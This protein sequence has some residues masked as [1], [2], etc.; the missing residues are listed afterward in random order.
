MEK[1]RR[2]AKKL[3]LMGGGQSCIPE[4]IY[5]ALSSPVTSQHHSDFVDI[6]SVI[7]AQL[8]KL[9]KT[10]NDVTLALPGTGSAGME[11][12]F[13]N[14]VEPGD[15]VLILIN[16]YFGQRMSDVASRLGAQVDTFAVPWGRPVL[17]ED[18]KAVLARRPYALVAMVHAETSTGATSPMEALGHLVRRSSE[19]LF[20][21]DCVSSLGGMAVDVDR[22]QADAA[23]SATQKCLSCPTGLAPLTISARAL[24]RLRR[25]KSKVPNW[26]LDL[27]M[28][29]DYWAR[30]LLVQHHTP[31]VNMLFALHAALEGVLNEGMSNVFVRHRTVQEQIASG[32][33]A[34][35]MEPFVSSACRAP[36]ITTVKVPAGMDAERVR[37]RLLADHDIDIGAGLGAYA[38]KMWRVGHMGHSARSG[39]AARFLEAFSVV[40][41]QE[42]S[43][44][45]LA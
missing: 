30:P 15:R 9:F 13:V 45:A 1:A 27:T 18:V 43:S 7:A 4:H 37:M 17:P 20:V 2:G 31:P 12:C 33:D 32:L 44:M 38:G 19:A 3:L 25:R 40:L 28:L 5:E 39:N 29:A 8:R 42:R 22:W 6:L 34:L 16:G 23:Y 35:G 10:E 11:T 41:D 24:E 26:Y 14:L 36:T 21:V